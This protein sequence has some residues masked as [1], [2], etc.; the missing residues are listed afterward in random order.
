MKPI[1]EHIRL[2]SIFH[3]VLG[4][5]LAL[6]GC[7][8]LIHLAM[9]IFFLTTDFPEQPAEQ[10]PDGQAQMNPE[11]AQKLVGAMFVIIPVFIILGFWAL[12]LL[13][14]IAG[15]KLGRYQAHTFCLVA[16]GASCLFM[17]F[18]TVL[19]VFTLIT[20]LKPEARDLFGLPPL[21]TSAAIT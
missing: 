18:G 9:G 8:P 17:P 2:L 14:I 1:E 16:A 6:F 15:R 7:F 10:M 19:G 11:D 13:I 5:M 12:A 21:E 20:L 3:Y 4:G